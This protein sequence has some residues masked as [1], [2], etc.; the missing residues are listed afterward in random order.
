MGK[1]GGARE[2]RTPDLSSAIAGK[3]SF[4]AENRGVTG[5]KRGVS[6]R[7]VHD[8]RSASDPRPHGT[9]CQA[10][11][12]AFF[13]ELNRDAALMAQAHTTATDCERKDA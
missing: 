9:C 6:S 7:F 3:T 4:L 1:V 5:A 10:L 12:L 11:M 8:M 2:D 13:A